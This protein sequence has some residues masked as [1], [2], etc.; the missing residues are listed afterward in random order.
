MTPKEYA[1]ALI[2]DHAA[3]AIDF[4]AIIQVFLAECGLPNKG[5]SKL[6]NVPDSLLWLTFEA[7]FFVKLEIMRHPCAIDGFRNALGTPMAQ[8]LPTDFEG[9]IARNKEY[10]LITVGHGEGIIPQAAMQGDGIMDMMREIGALGTETPEQSRAR[11]TYLNVLTRHVFSLGEP[12]LI[13]V[14]SSEQLLTPEIYASQMTQAL[15]AELFLQPLLFSSAGAIQQNGP[16]G[17]NLLGAQTLIGKD[18]VFSET[19]LPVSDVLTLPV[20]FVK[21]CLHIGSVLGQGETFGFTA[22]DK[23]HV[24]HHGVSANHPEGLI[25]LTVLAHANLPVGMS[26]TP[27]TPRPDEPS[28][29]ASAPTG[30]A[31][32][33]LQAQEEL[34][35]DAALAAAFRGDASAKK[36][37]SK[38]DAK[39]T[40]KKASVA[41][42]KNIGRGKLLKFVLL[43]FV[44][45]L[46]LQ[47]LRG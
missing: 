7:G 33:V 32:G 31:E 28:V 6:Q 19:H 41:K 38:P 20:A 15:P 11:L 36:S 25:E 43:L 42:G 37:A 30:G 34:P 10:V 23:V 2:Y 39:P 40:R 44:A 9:I 24:T 5:F 8:M 35:P 3:P 4:D 1:T 47:F 22:D 12:S 18:V 14:T 17:A 21:Y 16:L 26:V 29:A 27:P 13:H 45:V 46:A